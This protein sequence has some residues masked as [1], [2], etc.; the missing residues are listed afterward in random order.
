MSGELIAA[1]DLPARVYLALPG[2][3][4]QELILGPVPV[5]LSLRKSDGFVRLTFQGHGVEPHGMLYQ[6]ARF[7]RALAPAFAASF[8]ESIDR[9]RL[10][11]DLEEDQE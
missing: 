6:L 9:L 4:P 3:K 11:T 5:C 10:P 7:Q 2:M 8:A 1:I